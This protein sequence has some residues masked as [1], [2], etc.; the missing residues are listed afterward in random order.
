MDNDVIVHLRIDRRRI[1]FA[2]MPRSLGDK[3]MPLEHEM[4]EPLAGYH[5]FLHQD[6]PSLGILRLDT[7]NDQR[8]FL[9]TRRSLLA[10]SEVCA[11]YAEELQEVQ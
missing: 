7:K 10:L 6:N 5:F 3:S 1:M 11:K 4:A 8:W 2:L 9:V